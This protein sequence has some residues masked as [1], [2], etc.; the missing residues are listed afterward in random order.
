VTHTKP[1]ATC[2]NP[3]TYER[4]P[5]RTGRHPAYCSDP[6]Y[7]SSAKGYAAPVGVPSALELNPV[8]T[9]RGYTEEELRVMLAVEAWKKRTH[10]R[11]PTTI[12]LFEVIKSLGYSRGAAPGQSP[13]QCHATAVASPTTSATQSAAP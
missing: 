10:T 5:G 9:E 11:F 8:T 3:F 4:P 2:G 7:P 12:Q 13:D 6:C 1:C